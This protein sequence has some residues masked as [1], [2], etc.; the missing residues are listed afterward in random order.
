MAT[1]ISA[2]CSLHHDYF[3]LSSHNNGLSVQ[4]WAMPP[5]SWMLRKRRER[6]EDD[7]KM[8]DYFSLDDCRL[9]PG[10]ED[11]E[12]NFTAGSTTF[13][14]QAD[15][16]LYETGFNIYCSRWH[17]AIDKN[18]SRNHLHGRRHNSST[19]QVSSRFDIHSR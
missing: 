13:L 15:D 10:T 1:W 17:S 4:C 19:F 3:L 7:F 18:A 8:I 2:P 14:Y 16:T 11:V 5:K 6:E 12:A 9:M